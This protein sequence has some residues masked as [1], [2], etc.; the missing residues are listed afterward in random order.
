MLIEH[1]RKRSGAR[2]QHRTILK[3]TS[4]SLVKKDYMKKRIFQELLNA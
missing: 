1:T 2:G 4:V 3:T